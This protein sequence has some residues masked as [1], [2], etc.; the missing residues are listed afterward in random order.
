M[1]NH[2]ARVIERQAEASLHRYTPAIRRICVVVF[3]LTLGLTLG[4]GLVRYRHDLGK[5]GP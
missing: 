4:Q 3:C 2:S 1:P 5:T